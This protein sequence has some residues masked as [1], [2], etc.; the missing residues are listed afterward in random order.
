MKKL[1]P[2]HRYRTVRAAVEGDAP[3]P[4]KGPEKELYAL[5][6]G[7]KAADTVAGA[8][9]IH[10]YTFKR[11]TLESLLLAGASPKEI[12]QTVG[13]SAAIV[14]TYR[15]LF[16]DP[17][18]FEN[19]LDRIE[20]A[21]TYT[22]NEYG[23]E[24]KELAV[25]VGK[26]FLKVRLSQG[27]YVVSPEIA[28]GAIRATAFMMAQLAKANPINSNVAREAQRWA[29]ICLKASDDEKDIRTEDATSLRMELEKHNVSEN[30]ETSGIPPDEILH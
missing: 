9:D 6:K 12:E 1:S 25:N 17:S 24:M 23:K 20:Y 26:E 18:V 10:S 5:L 28:K 2:D 29:Q 22:G 3:V 13:V 11:E 27:I 8:Y 21:G 19:A 14:E 7:Q 30:A 15:T 4:I 16:F